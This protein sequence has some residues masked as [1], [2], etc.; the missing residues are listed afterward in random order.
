[1][2]FLKETGRTRHSENGV[3]TRLDRRVAVVFD[4]NNPNEWG[5]DEAEDALA[6]G[7]YADGSAGPG[8]ASVLTLNKKDIEVDP[9]ASH[10]YRAVCTYDAETASQKSHK[11]NDEVIEE[12]NGTE[13]IQVY[14]DEA[15]NKIA[16]QKSGQGHGVPMEVPKCRF[17]VK[18][19]HTIA[20]YWGT[21]RPLI[22]ACRCTQ[23]AAAFT[24][25]GGRQLA[26]ESAVL[27][28]LGHQMRETS[29]SLCEV[30]YT[31][32]EDDGDVPIAGGGSVQ[33]NHS[34]PLAQFDDD[35]EITDLDLVD[36]YKN[37]S[38]ANLM[39]EEP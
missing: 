13:T 31:L 2:A 35:D 7:G 34:Y 5:N 1:M 22:K 38:W 4:R 12:D 28:F 10:V 24:T 33:L 26:S 30:A 32:I 36:R 15:G 3:I 6:A 37:V 18:R 14:Y 19:Y 20:Y 29:K 8:D 17:V 11:K 21:L 16:S 23:N 39:K 27:L 25:P 9:K